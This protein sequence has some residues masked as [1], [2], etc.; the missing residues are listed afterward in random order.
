MSHLQLGDVYRTDNLRIIKTSHLKYH[1]G[2]HV[3]IPAY[4]LYVPVAN[5]AVPGGISSIRIGHFH[6]AGLR[7]EDNS[8]TTEQ[9][10]IR[11]YGEFWQW[12]TAHTVEI[13]DYL[14]LGRECHCTPCLEGR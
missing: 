1:D 8:A 13:S 4:Q 12:M 10:L 7:A 11:A 3:H 9:Q 5:T 14:D 2:H 6:Y